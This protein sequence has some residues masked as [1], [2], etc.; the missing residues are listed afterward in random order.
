M[1]GQLTYKNFLSLERVPTASVLV[2]VDYA[3]ID[4]DGN[5]ISV[6][7]PDPKVAALAF[8]PPPKYEAQSYS[9]TYFLNSDIDLEV[10]ALRK[11]RQTDAP[12]REVMEAIGEVTGKAYAD[13]KQMLDDFKVRL[14]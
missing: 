3:S 6:E 7:D 8:E 10:F 2:R 12:L 13:D 11:I 4:Y 9:T 14:S 1:S 5:F